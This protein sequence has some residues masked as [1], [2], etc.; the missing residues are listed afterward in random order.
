M[1]LIYNLLFC[2]IFINCIAQSKT[3]STCGTEDQAIQ[4]IS[5]LKEVQ[6]Q[7]KYIDSISNHTKGVSYMTDDKI[8]K[9]KSYFEVATGYNGETRWETY[10]LFYV[11][12]KN[13]ND[14]YVNE[15]VSGDIIPIAQW[16]KLKAKKV[17]H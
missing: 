7:Q 16:R 11:N 2:L 3:N 15:V 10:N 14:I 12:K 17:K 1:K 6:L 4:V 13:C 5:E 8:I 9:N